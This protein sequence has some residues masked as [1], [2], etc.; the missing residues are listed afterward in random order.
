MWGEWIENEEDIEIKAKDYFTTM[1]SSSTV[2]DL[3]VS[4]FHITRSLTA[5]MN[6]SLTREV[7]VAEVKVAVFAIHPGKELGPDLMTTLFYQK[8]WHI[9][10]PQVVEMIQQF[11]QTSI[12]DP[13]SNEINI[14]LIPK[15][16]RPRM[17]KEFRPISL[18]NVSYK[19]I[20]KVLCQRIKKFLPCLV[21]ETQSAFVVGRQIMDN[22]MLAQNDSY[23]WKTRMYYLQN[24][25]E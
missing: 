13:R 11:L 14:C 12:L 1:F 16:E 20:S 8:F 4:L 19:I 3:E 21:S 25:Y 10:G 17:M 22:I 24:R 7:S 9:I 6:E 5:E 23:H 2:S 15:A 18:C